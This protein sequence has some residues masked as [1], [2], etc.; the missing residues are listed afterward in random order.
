LEVAGCGDVDCGADWDEWEG[1]E[2]GR[3]LARREKM[4]RTQGT[5][6]RTRGR[7]MS[8]VVSMGMSIVSPGLGCRSRWQGGSYNK[9]RYE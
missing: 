8:K 4:W 5:E 9:M 1:E 2:D 6:L 7:L 3:L